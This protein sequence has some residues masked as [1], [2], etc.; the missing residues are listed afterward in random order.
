MYY[1]STRF[2]TSTILA[3]GE[4]IEIPVCR[5]VTFNHATFVVGTKQTK[6][7]LFQDFAFDDIFYLKRAA[8]ER[9]GQSQTI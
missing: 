8:K 3:R 2:S 6:R 1:F 7:S 4:M 5:G 9:K